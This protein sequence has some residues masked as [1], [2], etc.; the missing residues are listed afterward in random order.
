MRSRRWSDETA[1]GSD[2]NKLH[3]E[4]S[5]RRAAYNLPATKI[6][7]TIPGWSDETAGLD[8]GSKLLAEESPRTMGSRLIKKE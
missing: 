5:P 8:E 4:E 1:E 7:R 3:A 2:S 6:L